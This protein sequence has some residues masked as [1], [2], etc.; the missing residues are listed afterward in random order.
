MISVCLLITQTMYLIAIYCVLCQFDWNKIVYYFVLTAL[1]YFI[2]YLG[3]IFDFA[4]F[5]HQLKH[6]CEYR[7]P[8]R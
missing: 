3:N 1:F 4:C 7:R 6:S 8:E 2:T 5:Y